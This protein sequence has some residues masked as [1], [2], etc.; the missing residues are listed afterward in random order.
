MRVFV[1]TSALYAVL[2]ADDACHDVAASA[3]RRLLAA[4]DQLVTTNYVVLE[5]IALL[6]RRIGITAVRSLEQDLRPVIGVLWVDQATHA[7]ATA[8]LLASS[9]RSVS[10]VDWVSFEAMRHNLLRHA[11]AFDCHFAEQGFELL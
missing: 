3:L 6:Q 10:L 11:F 5:V 9:R 4:R 8:A 2:D 7:A 1:D